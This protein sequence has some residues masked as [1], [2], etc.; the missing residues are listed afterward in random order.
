MVPVPGTW[1]P[2]MQAAGIPI[3]ADA[4]NGNNL[5]A[6][7]ATSAVHPTNWTRSYS[8]SAYLDPAF[9]RTNPHVLVNATVTRVTSADNVVAGD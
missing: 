1:F 3:S 5:G 7:F 6:F 8:R 4:D 2:T 9:A